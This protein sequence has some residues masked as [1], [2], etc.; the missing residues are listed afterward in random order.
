VTTLAAGGNTLAAANLS[1]TLPGSNLLNITRR[2]INQNGRLQLL[3]DVKN[4][5]SHSVELG[6]FGMPQGKPRTI[7]YHVSKTGLKNGTTYLPPG[8]QLTSTKIA[9]SSIHT[10]A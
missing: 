7:H 2:W 6:S 9:P 8:M 5:N 3:F 10:L 4:S 1:P